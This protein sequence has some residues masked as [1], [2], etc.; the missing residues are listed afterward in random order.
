MRRSIVARRGC[1][2]P[3]GAGHHSAWPASETERASPATLPSGC[4]AYSSGWYTGY[5]K[6]DAITTE[7]AVTKAPGGP[8]FNR[9][10][11]S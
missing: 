8:V 9:R 11:L 6:N 1:G 2:H 10:S 7:A 4:T 3:L 5:V